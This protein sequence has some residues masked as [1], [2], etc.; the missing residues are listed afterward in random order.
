MKNTT[1]KHCLFQMSKKHSKNPSSMKQIRRGNTPKLREYL[2]L[3]LNPTSERL[4]KDCSLCSLCSEIMKT[5]S[6][7]FARMHIESDIIQMEPFQRLSSTI[8]S[9]I[10]H[11]AIQAHDSLLWFQRSLRKKLRFLILQSNYWR[12]SL[13]ECSGRL[14]SRVR[15]RSIWYICSSPSMIGS[16]STTLTTRIF[17]TFTGKQAYQY[18]LFIEANNHCYQ[19]RLRRALQLE[20]RANFRV[21]MAWSLRLFIFKT[22]QTDL[23]FPLAQYYLRL[24]TSQKREEGFSAER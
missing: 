11:P 14:S 7:S 6:K 24:K 23:T 9:M 17:M 1:K 4:S 19:V 15:Q 5:S 18:S 20:K 22:R 13:K 10:S 16:T 3:N 12:D 21:K 8:Y 2:T